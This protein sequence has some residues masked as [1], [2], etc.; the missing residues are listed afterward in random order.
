MEELD[1]ADDPATARWLIG[2]VLASLIW[3]GVSTPAHAVDAQVHTDWAY[4]VRTT[5]SSALYTQGCNWANN[6]LYYGW[7]SLIIL[8]FG[9]QTGDGSTSQ[10]TG[11]GGAVTN[12]Q[13]RDLSQSFAAG[14]AACRGPS[15]ELGIGTNNSIVPAANQT[16]GAYGTAWANTV[17]ASVKNWMA[18][19]CAGIPSNPS[20]CNITVVG[21][22]DMESWVG[23]GGGV[24]AHPSDD[25]A[26]MYSNAGIGRYYD[27]GSLDGC[28]SNRWDNVIGCNGG[29]AQ[30]DYQ[31]VSWRAPAAYATPE[32]Y[33]YSNEFQWAM[34]SKYG[35]QYWGGPT[36]YT[37]PLDDKALDINAYSPYDAWNNFWNALNSNGLPT[38]M[39][40]ALEMHIVS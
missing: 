32:I 20:W 3:S 39:N 14:Y 1:S 6:D 22:N 31:Y 33:Y 21:A 5:N 10:L 28:P 13:I 36:Y 7:S 38:G 35:Q 23:Q 40:R 29:W 8:D 30:A 27:F 9:G 24:G 11:G 37:G 17:V 2:L 16:Y 15:L 12:F 34:V 25:W 4:Y 26:N 19:Q 18:G